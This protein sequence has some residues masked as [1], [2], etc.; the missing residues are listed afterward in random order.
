MEPIAGRSKLQLVATATE[1][2][3]GKPLPPQRYFL[4]AS[5]V[6]F[7]YIYGAKSKTLGRPAT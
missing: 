4:V 7:L 2:T 1:G 6:S 5:R 3:W